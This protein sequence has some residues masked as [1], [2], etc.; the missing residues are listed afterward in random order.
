MIR[1]A[2]IND[3]GAI[4][5]IHTS[6]VRE[7]AAAHY[8]P[9]QVDVWVGRKSAARFRESISDKVVIVDDEAG[10]V[11][12]FAQLD[13]NTSTVEAVYVDPAYSRRGIG[14]RL[15]AALESSARASGTGELTLDA[16]LNSVSFYESAGYAV[17]ANSSHELAPGISISCI[18]M[19]K[20][21]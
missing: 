3:M 10:S 1:H 2:T 7:I 9:A 19:R 21:L 4:F 20:A 14:S 8:S 11:F 15:L 17:V 6:A 18:A 16:S 13:T 12:G 5:R